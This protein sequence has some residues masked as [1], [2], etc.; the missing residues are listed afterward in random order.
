VKKIIIAA[1]LLCPL[2]SYSQAES[3]SGND[4]NNAAATSFSYRLSQTTRAEADAYWA[5]S[6]AVISGQGHL[7]L[8]GGSGIDNV[9]TA[10]APNVDLVDVS[11]T[12]FEGIGVARYGFF[13]GTLYTIQTKLLVPPPQAPAK[14][15]R[16]SYSIED[17]DNVM[18]KLISKYGKANK[19]SGAPGKTPDT[20]IW[21]IGDNR[22]IFSRYTNGG[23][24]LILDNQKM[25]AK[26]KEYVKAVC[27]TYNTKD[28]IVCW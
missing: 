8:G 5:R 11:G 3:S 15:N 9:S 21:N 27:K 24:S 7:A 19:T 6:G 1:L 23:A 4:A 28:R 2:V 16:L 13:E 10:F 22:L 20:L 17:V 14:P 26:V 12:D 18:K 25:D